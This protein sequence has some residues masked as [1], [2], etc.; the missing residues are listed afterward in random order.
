MSG[1]GA[2]RGASGFTLLEMLVAVAILAALAAVIPRSL[3]SA[4]A[5]MDGSRN[6]MQARLVAEALLADDLGGFAQRPGIRRGTRDGHAWSAVLAPNGTVAASPEKS[7]R[8][9]LDLRLAV[10]VDGAATL[11]VETLRIG[12]AR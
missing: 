1:G 5:A 12:Y 6:W 11:R 7:D 4:R 3:V 8:V 10:Q 9:L 2:R